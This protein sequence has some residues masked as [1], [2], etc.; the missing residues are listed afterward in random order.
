MHDEAAPH[1]EDMINNM[2][3][4]HEWLLKELGAVPRIGWHVDPF[5]HSTANPR[6]FADMGFD[7]WMFARI[8]W[9]DKD[10]R[11][12][13][14]SM[15]FLWRPMKE[16]FGNQKEIFTAVMQDHY[17]WS[18]GMWY[19]ERED[20]TNDDPV[21]D[22]PRLDDFNADDKVVQFEDYIKDMNDN[23]RGNH[24]MVP[25]GC[26]FTHAN[27]R[28]AFENMDRFINYFNSHTD[29]NIVLQYS[30]PGEYLDALHAQDLT[31]PVKY[32]DMFPYADNPQDFWTGYFAS[33][34]SA[35]K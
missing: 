16:H 27:A 29:E 9:D 2:M 6:L 1:Y 15:N 5:G 4:G 22:D 26:D 35:K 13:D 11:L 8:S 33:R 14:Q 10:Q 30:T 32:D 7:A 17:C 18:Q 19:D 31:W 20:L 21:V 25:M 34:M 28:Q 3:K 12:K 24:M 23:Y